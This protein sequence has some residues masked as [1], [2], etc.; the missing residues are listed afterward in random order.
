MVRVWMRVLVYLCVDVCL[1]KCVFVMGVGVTSLSVWCH[2]G[3]SDL[4]KGGGL[5]E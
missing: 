2:R 3:Y 4:V 1:I 5:S